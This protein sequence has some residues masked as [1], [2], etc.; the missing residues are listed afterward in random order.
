MDTDTRQDERRADGTPSDR[1]PGGALLQGAAGGLVAT[2]VM[3]VF[4]MSI[5]RSLPPTAVFW[6]RFVGSG[7][8]EE[9]ATEGLA[10]HLGYGMAAGVAF[11]AV[12][13]TGEPAPE[14]ARERQGAIWGTLYGIALS[15]FGLRV[16]LGWLLG[17]DL[18]PD[19]RWIFHVGHVIYG[20]TLGS[21][22]GSRTA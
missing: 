16:V 15:A 22:L 5:A 12:F 21:W 8:P 1:R 4:R 9:Y 7:P 19:E 17:M 10:L 13:P 6:S 3:T 2:A 14:V 20:L 18:D 11:A